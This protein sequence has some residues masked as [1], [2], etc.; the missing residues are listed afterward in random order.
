MRIFFEI[1][2]LKRFSK[3]YKKNKQEKTE[4]KLKETFSLNTKWKTL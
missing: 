4:N 3:N 2:K 1:K